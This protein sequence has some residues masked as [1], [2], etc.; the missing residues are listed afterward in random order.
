MTEDGLR[1]QKICH[2][3]DRGNYVETVDLKWFAKKADATITLF[4]G[5][6]EFSLFTTEL[7]RKVNHAEGTLMYRGARK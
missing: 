1:M 4:R 2:D 3:M 7:V 6:K 5:V